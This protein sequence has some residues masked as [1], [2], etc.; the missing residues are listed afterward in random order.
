[1]LSIATSSPAQTR[2]PVPLTR[3]DFADPEL[4]EE[5]LGAVREVAEKGAFTLG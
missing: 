2:D 3:L 5:L 1:M 4:L